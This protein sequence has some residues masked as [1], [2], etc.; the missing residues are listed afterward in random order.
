M[1]QYTF[2]VGNMYVTQ[3]QDASGNNVANPTPYPLMV[4]QEGS[5]DISGDIKELY[6]QNQFAVAIGRGKAKVAVKVKPARIFA[7][8]WNAI[9]FGQG[10][11]AGLVAN[12]TDGTGTAVPTT[13]FQIT[14]TPP[15]SGVWAADMGVINS[16]TGVPLKRGATATGTGVYA[17]TAGVYTFN[18]ADVGVVM[19]INF[20]YTVAAASSGST[21]AVLNLPMGYAPFFKADLTVVYAS[22][23]VTFSFFRCVSSKF[24]FGLKNED[25][26]VP[27]FDFS[28]MDDG[29]GQVMKWST[30]E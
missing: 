26:A 12:F 19:L 27:E 14:P 8:L 2:G 30:S 6:G 18:T 4:L 29:T 24:N 23:I 3:L 17:V 28:P 22:K 16:V 1:S 7:G 21:Q 10:N 5:I 25:F 15:S 9:F 13:P 20:Q 11:A